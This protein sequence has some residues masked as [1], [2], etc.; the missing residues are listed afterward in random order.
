MSKQHKSSKVPKIIISSE[1]KKDIFIIFLF[2]LAFL[3][4]LAL[5]NLAGGV[6]DSLQSFW[7][8]T[9]GWS[10][11]LTPLALIVIG[12]III[13]SEKY[14]SNTSRVLGLILMILSFLGILQL[15]TAEKTF[16]AAKNGMGGGIL[17]Y[18]VANPLEK[19]ANTPG[20]IIILIA[21]F[22]IAVL[23][24]FETS[25]KNLLFNLNW[26]NFNFLQKIKEKISKKKI[27]QQLEN[28][29]A[30]EV[31][32]EQKEIQNNLEQK[33]ISNGENINA[34]QELIHLNK[35][36]KTY[37]KIDLPLELLND[38]STKPTA[39]NIKANQEIIKNTLKH[40]GIEV[41]MGEISV[42]PT[43]TQYTFKPMAGIKVSQIT[44]LSNDLALALA[45]HP[46]RIEAPIPGK[47]LVGIEVPNQ[48]IALVT[49]KEIL[50]SE[51]FKKRT[52]HLFIALGKD[53]AGAPQLA[54]LEKMPHLLVA[55]AT[56]SGKTVCLN[57]VIISL[58]YQN[59][60]DELKFI[61]I[62]PKQVEMTQYNNV[63]HLICPVITEVKETINALRWAVKEMEDRFKTLA[64][65]GKRNIDAYNQTARERMPYLIIVID[66]LADLM[67]IAANDIEPAIIRLAQKARAVGIHLIVATQRPSVNVITGLIKANITSRIA[68]SV[69]ASTDSR[70]ILD[71]A[72]AEKLLGRGDMLFISADLSKPKR[73]QGAYLS[74]QEID[75]VVNYLKQTG[76]PEYNDA[77]TQKQISVDSGVTGFIFDDSD[78]DLLEEAKDIILKSGKASASYLQRRLSIGYA[79]AARILDLLEERGIVGHANGSKPRDVLIGR[80]DYEQDQTLHQLEQAHEELEE[81]EEITTDKNNNE[82]IDNV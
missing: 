53:V 33:N 28:L 54:D 19:I 14:E 23:L 65:A 37:P 25:I 7:Q 66:E 3:S 22:L 80:D 52:S 56:N 71:H 78:D 17:G 69:A 34:E 63:P 46:I 48:K 31:G 20:A 15:F 9:F 64:L 62:D 75:K 4:L 16:L 81:A 58:L 76:E 5:F 82:D 55:G 47:S 12:Y 21:L 49:L 44:T 40:F 1:T 77:V 68:F 72:G 45:A 39:G 11:W 6:G 73:I 29:E 74:D 79:R 36:K 24:F 32:F 26:S 8:M 60:P 30:E 51:D 42:G 18:F 13:N 38:K 70:T 57:S 27:D 2:A 10:Y 35:T 50:S 59:Q 61:L 43:V 41:E 67:S